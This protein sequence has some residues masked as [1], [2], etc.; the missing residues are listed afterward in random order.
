MRSRALALAVAAGFVVLGACGKKGPPLAPL[1]PMPAR[2]T[3]VVV[4]AADAQVVLAIGVPP[5]NADGT[6]PSVIDA[7][8]IYAQPGE[9]PVPVP[10][11]APGAAPPAP[12]AVARGAPA[13]SIVQPANLIAT[14]KVERAEPPPGETEGEAKPS[15]VTFAHDLAALTGAAVGAPPAVMR[16]AVV[17][18]GRGRRGPPSAV[19]AVP[20]GRRPAA[21]L[22]VRAAFDESAITITWQAPGPGLSSHVDELSRGTPVGE[23]ERRSTSPVGGASFTLPV[24]FGTTRCFIVRHV[25]VA[26]QAA[27]EG[28]AA[29]PVC[30]SATDTF[31]PPVPGAFVA[32][33]EEGAV[34]LSWRGVTAPDLA[35]YLVLRGEG[36]SET[37]QPLTPAPVA[38]RSYRDATVRPGVMYTYAVVAVDQAVPPNRS[39]ESNRQTVTAREP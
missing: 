26:G 38:E 35:G 28:P 25:V 1:R 10:V 39:G 36:A 21:P 3:D 6:T 20:L 33:A 11:A 14:V 7:V 12:V 32:I 15:R 27:V 30:V 17:G 19:V 31:P 13:P 2:I 4:R 16:Y 24:T 18:I 8:E 37:L 22:D 5:A 34:V 29:E 23:P 9:A